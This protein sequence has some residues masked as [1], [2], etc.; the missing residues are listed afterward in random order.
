[1]ESFYDSRLYLTI[2]P[3]CTGGPGSHEKAL[4]LK[5]VGAARNR[6]AGRKCNIGHACMGALSW[7]HIEDVE[8]ERE[9]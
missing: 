1:M 2:V 8:R 7:V 5:M 3:G 4:H 9:K 6:A